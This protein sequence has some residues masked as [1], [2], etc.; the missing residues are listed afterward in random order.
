MKSFSIKIWVISVM[1]MLMSMVPVFAITDEEAASWIESNV[2]ISGEN[3]VSQNA[4]VKNWLTTNPDESDSSTAYTT[5]GGVAVYIKS[6]KNESGLNNQIE[7]QMNNDNT[8]SDVVDITDGLG[9]QADTTGATAMLSG[10][11]PILSLVIGVMV[12]LITVGMTIFSA[13]DIAYI[14]FPVFRN[15]C[16]EAKASGTGPMVGK[17]SS[18]ET[19]LKIVTMDAQYAVQ[20]GSIENGKSPWV[21]YFKQ[22]IF[23]YIML[24][25]ILFILMTG[26][27]SLIT[28][29]ALNLVSGIMNIL[30]G[31]A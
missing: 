28:N 1:V 13:F 15:K 12:V 11:M 3:I 31:L 25:I 10:F 14:A 26:N 22:R 27:I 30:S 20:Q 9:L 6:G 16:E 8:V 4:W 29:I 21:L 5:I 23:S 2:T 18:G 24:A 19:K 17:T 7:M